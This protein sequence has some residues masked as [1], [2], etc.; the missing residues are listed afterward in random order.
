M[1]V[2]TSLPGEPSLYVDS[3][4]APTGLSTTAWMYGVL[5]EQRAAPGAVE[6]VAEE[7]HARAVGVRDGADRADR[8]GAA[9]SARPTPRR[10]A[11]AAAAGSS[12]RAATRPTSRAASRPCARRARTSP[13]ADGLRP[14]SVSGPARLRLPTTAERVSERRADEGGWTGS[15]RICSIG[16]ASPTV[17]PYWP[18]PAGDGADVAR[19]PVRRRAVDRRAREARADAGRVDG[20]ARDADED[21]RGLRPQAVDDVE[22]LDVE[23]RDRR[24]AHDRQRGAP[25][26]GLDVAERHDRVGGART[27]RRHERSRESGEKQAAHALRQ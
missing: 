20:R 11:R 24:A 12:R 21:A 14:E 16:V 27:G 1:I 26:P 25:H 5:E 8:D 18:M 4:G 23:A 15:A 3:S 6:R 2:P 19:D 13:R 17:P 9:S 10:P 22:H 7:P